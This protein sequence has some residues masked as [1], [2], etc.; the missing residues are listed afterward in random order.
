MIWDVMTLMRHNLNDQIREEHILHYYIHCNFDKLQVN[1]A[2]GIKEFI[3][4]FYY[5]SRSIAYLINVTLLH[6]AP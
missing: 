5:C 4:L 2:L 3:V 1:Y 6:S